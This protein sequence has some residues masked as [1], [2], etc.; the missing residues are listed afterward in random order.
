MRD[1]L[2]ARLRRLPWWLPVALLT[3]G[4]RLLYVF[5]AQPTL[6]FSTSQHYLT[7][8]LEVVT[9]AQPL[10]YIL[11][12]DG[13]HMFNDVWTVAPLYPLFV[14]GVFALFGAKLLSVQ[15]AQA[16][17]ET[18]AAVGFAG[19]GRR[20]SPRFGVWAGVAYALWWPA[21]EWSGQTMTEGLHNTIMSLALVVLAGE[22]QRG[23]ELRLRRA[24]LGAALLGLGAFVRPVSLTFLPLAGLLLAYYAGRKRA[25]PVLATMALAG[26]LVVAPWTLRNVICRGDFVVIESISA[27]TLWYD[28]AFVKPG[29]YGQQDREILSQPTPAERRRKALE[30]AWRNI[31][32]AP[33]QL[34]DKAWTALRHFFRPEGLHGWLVLSEPLPGWRHVARVFSDDLPVLLSMALLCA[35]LAAGRGG[36]PFA[37]VVL[38]LGYLLF[39]L[40]VVFHTEVRYRIGF[41]P[42]LFA[43]AACGLDALGESDPLRRRRARWTAG[44]ALVLAGVVLA[45]YAVRLVR[46]TRAEL[47]LGPARAAIQRGDLVQAESV[48]R[49]AGELAPDTAA[50]YL[51]YGSWLAASGYAGQ[52][53][54][55]YE[56]AERRQPACWLPAAVL[57]QLLRQAGDVQ[58]AELRF[59]A[60]ARAFSRP[61]AWEPLGAAWA[62]LPAPRQD[63]IVFGRDDFGALRGFGEL[64]AG[65]RWTLQG[66]ALRLLPTR[67]ARAYALT[68]VIGSPQPSPLD[69]PEVGVRASGRPPF[70]LRVSRT[71]APYTFEAAPEAGGAIVVQL[72]GPVWNRPHGPLDGGVRVE[73]LSVAPLEPTS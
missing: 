30:L 58:A 55:V 16:V 22:A 35:A 32:A 56:Q 3:L 10:Q 45:P 54:R 46:V 13:W 67:P 7:G 2:L 29:R 4:V 11:Y 1:A 38:W 42:P 12:D 57:P 28:N 49:E 5:G 71:M 48:V 41:T 40:V 6:R 24:A 19:L 8:A 65:G 25:A 15:I 72:E 64:R 36:G 21:I 47:R 59:T 34:P 53:A 27:Y 33:E 43:A 50:P 14:A 23:P 17:L 39:M 9:H 52:A 68:L 63:E 66:A 31:S 70:N 37:L 51:R 20:L 60:V 44:L 69:E 62:A 18:V 26:C 61:R 73:R